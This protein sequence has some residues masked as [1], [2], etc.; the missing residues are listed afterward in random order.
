MDLV[1]ATITT[2]TTNCTFDSSY[3]FIFHQIT[4]SIIFIIGLVGNG[5]ALCRFCRER[6][7]ISSTAVYMA[8]LSV[9]DLIF[10]ASLPLRIYYYH[11]TNFKSPVGFYCFLTFTLKYISL[12][13]GI[14]FL[15][16]IAADRLVAV[17]YPTA[18]R[19]RRL[20]TARL[21]STVVWCLILTLSI[22]IPILHRSST[23]N[24]D[25]CLLDP[26]SQQNQGFILIVLFLVESAFLL[27]LF[28]LL[29]SYCRIVHTLRKSSPLIFRKSWEK[30]TMR[31][32]YS[33]IAVFLLC[34]GPYHLNL[35]FYTLGKVGLI[36]NCNVS[37]LTRALQPV[38]LSLASMNC[39]F[40]P[41][42][43]YFSSKMFR[44]DAYM[45]SSSQ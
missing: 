31:M 18:K 5:L 38:V 21:I 1:N 30:R 17:V 6:K 16:C 35:F 3:R 29:F 40:N 27:P 25:P 2:E 26:S 45:N 9:A 14:F 39:C 15:V 20:S 34:F 7:N 43:Y 4:Y 36:Q 32:I 22:S 42:I 33:V 37:K 41:L 8:N 19:L 44:K 23:K 10:V 13:G 12:Y 11:L 28:L 24:H